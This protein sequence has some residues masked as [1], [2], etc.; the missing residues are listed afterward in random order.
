MT[1]ETVLNATEK[2]RV[3]AYASKGAP[4]TGGAQ[5]RCFYGV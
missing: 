3:K 4:P 5:D 2:Y 1:K